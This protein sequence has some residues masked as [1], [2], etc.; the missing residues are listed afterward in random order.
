VDIFA[1][2]C[3]GD[4]L[5]CRPDISYELSSFSVRAEFRSEHRC[6]WDQ[7]RLLPGK[8]VISVTAFI[9]VSLV[10]A[11]ATTDPSQSTLQI[12]TTGTTGIVVRTNQL[13]VFAN[14]TV[15]TLNAGAFALQGQQPGLNVVFENVNFLDSLYTGTVSGPSLVQVRGLLINTDSV[16][17]SNCI[18][19]RNQI[20]NKMDGRGGIL[21][22]GGGSVSVQNCYFVN[23]TESAVAFITAAGTCIYMAPLGAE[24]SGRLSISRSSFVNNN[25]EG[26]SGDFG[27]AIYVEQDAALFTLLIQD[28]TFISNHAP[29]DGGCIYFGTVTTSVMKTVL[30]DANSG[31]IGGNVNGGAVYISPTVLSTY[32]FQDVTFRGNTANSGGAL[33]L[34]LKETFLNVFVLT[35]NN[36]F[37][38]LSQSTFSN[39]FFLNN[40]ATGVPGVGGAIFVDGSAVVTLQGLFC[41]N[42]ALNIDDDYVCSFT[43]NGNTSTALLGGSSFQCHTTNPSCIV[44]D[45]TAVPQ[46]CL[47]AGLS[48]PCTSYPL[49]TLAD[50]IVAGVIVVPVLQSIIISSSAPVTTNQTIVGNVVIYGLV[51]TQPDVTVTVTGIATIQPGAVLTLTVQR[52]STVTILNAAFV[53]GRF[54]STN[55]TSSSSCNSPSALQPTYSPLSVTLIVQCDSNNGLST[56]AIVGIAVG[57][58]V[59]AILVVLCVIMFH[60]YRQSHY[61]NAVN[62]KLKKNELDDISKKMNPSINL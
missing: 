18:F 46:L 49:S 40:S 34:R 31:L 13:V 59:V 27:G 48:L 25:L 4:D 21:D 32:D 57:V 23:N 26:V 20:R 33:S 7:V 62:A 47:G 28:C 44:G 50:Q 5:L 61:T 52:T 60:K 8:Y 22:I 11:G 55:L 15:T 58:V 39:C 3:R 29:D 1:G 51:I 9:N 56:G 45:G 6:V 2:S 54:A 24:S 41:G 17:F 43:Y 30:F 38:G 14:L 42:S 37:R 19:A 53:T 16:S 10:L 12:Q 35:G 36:C